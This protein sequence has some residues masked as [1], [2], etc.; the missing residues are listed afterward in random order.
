[1]VVALISSILALIIA[2]IISRKFTGSIL[3]MNRITKKD[4]GSLDFSEKCEIDSRDEFGQLAGSIDDLFGIS[5]FDPK[6]AR[7]EERSAQKEIEH[8]K[9]VEEM[10]KQFITNVSHELKTPLYAYSGIR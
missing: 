10:R 2:F 6:R 9:V 4:E 5:R 3:H 7:R 1:M 8:K